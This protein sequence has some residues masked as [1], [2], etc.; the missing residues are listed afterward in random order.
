MRT[1]VYTD[2]QKINNTMSKGKI[3]NG[4]DKI[5]IPSTLLGSN[6]DNVNVFFELEQ[7][8]FFQKV[9]ETITDKKG[10]LRFKRIIGKKDI[11]K[12]VASDLYVFSSILGEPQTIQAKCSDRS[13]EPYHIIVTIN[14]KEEAMAHLEYTVCESEEQIELEWSGIKQIIEFNSEEM[15]PFQPKK[16]ATLSYTLDSIILNARKVDQEL[17][18]QL[19]DYEQLIFGGADE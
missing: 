11:E 17:V 3:N 6:I 19:L 2:S 12:L 18:N 8:P 9:K 10:V 13:K 7:Y 15:N 1:I 5:Y 14:Y 4:V 16:Y